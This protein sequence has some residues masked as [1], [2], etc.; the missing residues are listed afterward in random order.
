MK[1]TFTLSHPKLKVSRVVE[2][3]KNDVRK[4][5]RR[6]RKKKLPENANFWNF[7]CKFGHTEKE[8]EKIHEP[9]IIKCIDEAEYL[10]LDSFYL[11]ILAKPGFKEKKKYSAEK[12]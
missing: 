3:I 12:E 9:E 11:E 5:L 6:E 7:D 10:K 2:S 1:K 4:Y 8:A